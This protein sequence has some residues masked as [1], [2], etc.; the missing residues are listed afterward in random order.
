MDFPDKPS[1]LS[2]L[3]AGCLLSLV[4]LAG[5]PA[6]ADKIPGVGIDYFPGRPDPYATGGFDRDAF[7]ARYGE[8]PEGQQYWQGMV[9]ELFAV[10]QVALRNACLAGVLGDPNVYDCVP[11]M[12]EQLDLA[13]ATLRPS[14]IEGTPGET[15]RYFPDN[16]YCKWWWNQGKQPGRTPEN[17]IQVSDP[18]RPAGPFS[19]PPAT[20]WACPL[21]QLN[22]LPDQPL[23]IQDADTLCLSNRFEVE[24]QWLTGTDQGPGQAKRLT[25]DTGTFSFLDPDNL[26]LFVK[27]LDACEINGNYW[28]FASG[29]TN[30][31][32]NLRVRDTV[33][34]L[35]RTY[36]NP[37]NRP[38]P[39]LQ[40]VSDFPCE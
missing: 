16:F 20:G 19:T 17:P 28:V 13:K 38:Y 36:V 4:V 15:F 12:V 37:V 2:R 10:N 33:T 1:R 29:L 22:V 35:E 18:A 11:R 21:Y 24:I 9:A 8:G 6:A 26:E 32:I 23:C 31:G 14:F 39:P 3:V 40:Q 30:V 5:I 7:V 27:V 34:E 25:P